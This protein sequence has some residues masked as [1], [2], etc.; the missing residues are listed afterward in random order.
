MRSGRA[1]VVFVIIAIVVITVLALGGCDR[2]PQK[3]GPTADPSASA[4]LTIAPAPW[5]NGRTACTLI[6]ATWMPDGFV[7]ISPAG[8][9]SAATLN[10]QM[11][12]AVQTIR[13]TYTGTQIK[14]KAGSQI[15]MS[16]YR[17]ITD[18]A[19]SCK[20][21]NGNDTVVITFSDADHCLVTRTSNPYAAQMK[22]KRLEG[23]ETFGAKP[24]PSTSASA[25]A[26]ASTSTSASASVSASASK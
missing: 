12:D 21:I 10:A 13:I 8:S 2:D 4:P 6:E 19:T 9:A 25:S 24:K 15:S 16:S 17:V 26:S 14:M 1:L 18:S 11:N 23:D 20:L 3:G 5:A 7:G 22:L